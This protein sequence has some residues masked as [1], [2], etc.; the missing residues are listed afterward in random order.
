MSA[1]EPSLMN[2]SARSSLLAKYR[3]NVR[4]DTSTASVI[5]RT[6]VWS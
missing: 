5:S 6:A 3:K 4:S 1:A 2:D